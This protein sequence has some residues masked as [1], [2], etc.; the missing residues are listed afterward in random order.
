MA[1]IEVEVEINES[2]K[3]NSQSSVLEQDLYHPALHTH[4][5]PHTHAFVTSFSIKAG[6]KGQEGSLA[7][8]ENAQLL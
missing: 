2:S 3:S 1:E 5:P 6:P 4:S 8:E 7:E